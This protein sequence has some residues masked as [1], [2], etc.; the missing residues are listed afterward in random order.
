MFNPPSDDTAP[1]LV[2]MH[3]LTDHIRFILDAKACAKRADELIS[4]TIAANEAQAAAAKQ[5]ASLAARSVDMD[6]REAGLDAVRDQLRERSDVI[7]GRHAELRT[8]ATSLRSLEAVIKRRLVDHHHALQGLD[9]NLVES[10]LISVP[11]WD[12]LDAEIGTPK[13]AHYQA[14]DHVAV[15]AVAQAREIT[16]AERRSQRRGG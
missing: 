7:E 8:V 12:S 6:K 2:E 11:S 10:R 14:S 13:D 3:R 1:N 4:L 16:G 15:G 9:A 5:E